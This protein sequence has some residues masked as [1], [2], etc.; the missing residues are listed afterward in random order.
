[1]VYPT[2]RRPTPH[3]PNAIAMIWRKVVSTCS[4]VHHTTDIV[5]A[6]PEA[7]AV[8]AGRLKSG[9]VSEFNHEVALKIDFAKTLPA[10][11]VVDDSLAQIFRPF[12][13]RLLIPQL[14]EN[15]LA[16]AAANEIYRVDSGAEKP[17]EIGSEF[18]VRDA[19]ESSV[20]IV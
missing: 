16:A 9:L 4:V 6:S 8:G 7:L 10:G 11:G 5:P 18:D 1:M 17:T 3:A 19:G 13:V 15:R 20:Q 2:D 14:G 12:H